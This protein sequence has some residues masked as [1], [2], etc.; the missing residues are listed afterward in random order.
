MLH[1]KY[2][3]VFSAIFLSLSLVYLCGRTL[4][5]QAEPRSLT[6][7]PQVSDP[8]ALRL[9]KGVFSQLSPK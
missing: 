6:E 8:L 5:C 7:T 4:Q 3:C 1:V 2:T 9:S